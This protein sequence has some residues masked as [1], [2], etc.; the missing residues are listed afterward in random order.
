MG[1]FPLFVTLED[2]PCLLVGAGTVALRKARVLLPCGPRLTVV[3]PDI[4][5][6]FAEMEQEGKLR[7]LRREFQPE[8][9]A[10]QLLVIAATNDRELNRGIAG[11]CRDRHILVNTSGGQDAC[12]CSFPAVVRRGRLSIG[13]STGGASPSAALFF[14]ERIESL[15]PPGG[16]TDLEEILDWLSKSRETVKRRLPARRRA[17]VFAALFDRCMAA[18][19]GLTETEL[20]QLLEEAAAEHE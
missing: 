6:V 18:G 12:T 16:S 1:D 13:I 5:P 9:L 19:R 17:P 3:A 7:L 20:E 10:E 4:L 11:L 2:A 14:K 15:F 8:D